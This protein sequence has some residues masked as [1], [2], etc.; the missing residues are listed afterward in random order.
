MSNSLEPHLKLLLVF[1]FRVSKVQFLSVLL[2]GATDSGFV[3]NLLIYAHFQQHN[4]LT[5]HQQPHQLS[6]NTTATK[7]LG[8]SQGSTGKHI[9]D[10]V[11]KLLVEFEIPIKKLICLGVDGCLLPS[12]HHFWGLNLLQLSN[13]K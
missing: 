7:F 2:D 11:Q 13:L 4:T 10:A 12:S 9:S 3:D 8:L 6:I 5:K 1:V